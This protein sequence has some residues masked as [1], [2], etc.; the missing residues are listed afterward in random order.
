MLSAYLKQTLE[1]RARTTETSE[2]SARRGTTLSTLRK[3]LS[4]S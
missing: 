2:G 3:A 1:T 4:S